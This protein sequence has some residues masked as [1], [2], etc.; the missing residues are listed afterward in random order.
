M[1]CLSVILYS[2]DMPRPGTLPPSDL[3]NHVCDL[4]LFSY[5][6]VCFSVPVSDV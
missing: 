4:C 5:P 2:G 1:R 3:L 6:N